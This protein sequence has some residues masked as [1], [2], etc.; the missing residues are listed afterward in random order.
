[1][2][3][4][5]HIFPDA[6]VSKPAR[7]LIDFLEVDLAGPGLA[8]AAQAQPEPDV[9]T[10]EIGALREAMAVLTCS[11][12]RENLSL[13]VAAA[14]ASGSGANARVGPEAR[15]STAGASASGKSG[16]ASGVVGTGTTPTARGSPSLGPRAGA[17]VALVRSRCEVLSWHPE[18]GSAVIVAGDPYDGDVGLLSVVA[19]DG[20]RFCVPSGPD[21]RKLVHFA[22]CR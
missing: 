19:L 21:V 20:W 15:G 9:T 16:A 10:L 14:S 5:R 22:E 8:L 18:F 2:E 1:M 3:A 11:M 12:E 13:P 6:G 7:S 17:S 4:L